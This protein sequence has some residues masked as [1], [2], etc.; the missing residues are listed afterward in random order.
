MPEKAKFRTNYQNLL[1][2]DRAILVKVGRRHTSNLPIMESGAAAAAAA[3]TSALSKVL[4]DAEFHAER[5]VVARQKVISPCCKYNSSG[6]NT[7]LA[8]CAQL[9]QLH[10]SASIVYDAQVAVQAM[11]G[12]PSKRVWIAAGDLFIR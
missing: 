6:T 4:A 1:N 5:A 12:P 3:N 9:A 11:P 10:S 2:L 7:T 8:V